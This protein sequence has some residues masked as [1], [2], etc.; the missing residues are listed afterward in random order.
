[1]K[2]FIIL[3]VNENIEYL[4][5]LPLVVWSWRRIGWEP[6]LFYTREQ[7]RDVHNLYTELEELTLM[8]HHSDFHFDYRNVSHIAGY[9]SDTI[10]QV[11]RL[12]AACLEVIGEDDYIMTGDI[13]MMALS[14]YWQFDPEKITVWGDDLTGYKHYPICYIGA[15]KSKWRQFMNLYSNEEYHSDD[16][17]EFIKRDLDGLPQAKDPD[18]WKYWF[19]DQDLVT[20]RIKDFCEGI[21]PQHR[22]QYSNGLARWRVDRGE[23][24]LK[25]D[26]FV[27]A[28][29]HRDIFKYFW[30]LKDEDEVL[31]MNKATLY[32]KKWNETMALLEKV[33]PNEDWDWFVN[34]TREYARLTQP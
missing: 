5:Y 33:W 30:T 8:G 25:H 22:G 7:K 15:K 20:Q 6:I 29:L 2:K 16:Y 18:F 21:I 27:D 32:S 19:S 26:K 1:M 4:F 9:R 3:S 11:S 31:R 12:Y 23:W 17:N 10:C 24:S 34:Y 28:H 14:D 13:D